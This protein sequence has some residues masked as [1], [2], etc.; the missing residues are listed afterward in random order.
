MTV[1]P[2]LIFI[3]GGLLESPRN[4][5]RLCIHSGLFIFKKNV[6]PFVC[7]KADLWSS[8][9]WIFHRGVLQ[10]GAGDMLAH[11]HSPVAFSAQLLL[12]LRMVTPTVRSTG[13]CG[14]VWTPLCVF[15]INRG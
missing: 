6:F 9:P 11:G 8:S 15:K 5:A 14:F 13:C 12:F 7:N 4:V 3:F 10:S 1:K 2:L